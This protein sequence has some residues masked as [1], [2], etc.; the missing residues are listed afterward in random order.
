VTIVG[1]ALF[2]SLAGLVAAWACGFA[3]IGEAPAVEIAGYCFGIKVTSTSACE[4]IDG[5]IYLFP[6]MVFGIVFGPLLLLSR[7][8]TA[9][10]AAAYAAAATLANVLAV[11]VCVSLQHPLDDL[12]PFENPILEL[13]LG[14]AA[15]G[16][17]GGGLLGRA[18]AGL[19]RAVRRRI[20]IGVAAGLG[21]LT[22]LVIMFDDIGVY[23]FY[24]LW[25]GGYAAAIAASLPDRLNAPTA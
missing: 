2:G 25:Q 20:Q 5:A 1:F 11:F 4:A 23:A 12:L 24:V 18:H 22:P 3:R 9:M 17:A 13:A 19:D 16:A 15:A 10:A 8:L 21:V 14:G 7:R 6:G